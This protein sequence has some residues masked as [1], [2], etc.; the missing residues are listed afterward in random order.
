MNYV[1][2]LNNILLLD[3]FFILQILKVLCETAIAVR[4]KAMKCLTAVVEADPGILARVRILCFS[5]TLVISGYYRLLNRLKCNSE[6]S[7]HNKFVEIVKFF[8]SVRKNIYYKIILLNSSCCQCFWV[9]TLRKY[10]QVHQF[11]LSHQRFCL[12]Y[13]VAYPY[14]F[15][16]LLN[17][18]AFAVARRICNKVCMADS[19]TSR[20]L[21]G[22]QPLNLL[23]SSFSSVQ[24]LQHSI[25]ICSQAEFS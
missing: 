5:G 9:F 7:R 12:D 17:S 14:C 6:N 16:A 11:E 19:W 24:N 8:E 23:A 15:L 21:Y 18:Y 3:V 13:S 4:T 25:M 2:F 1:R 22:R 20:R 10:L